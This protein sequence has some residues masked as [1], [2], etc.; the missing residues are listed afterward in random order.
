MDAVRGCSV[1]VPLLN[2]LEDGDT[3]IRSFGANQTIPLVLMKEASGLLTP[4]FR[5]KHQ[6][7]QSF[8]IVNNMVSISHVAVMESCG[9]TL[10][11]PPHPAKTTCCRA[12][13]SASRCGR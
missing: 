9:L 8:R 5:F 13:R 6:L 4:R 11:F 1:G 12:V 10:R 3:P 7:Y 2:L